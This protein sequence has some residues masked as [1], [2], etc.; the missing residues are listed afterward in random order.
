M[1]VCI[2][3]F[4]SYQLDFENEMTRF[5][6]SVGADLATKGISSLKN[7]KLNNTHILAARDGIVSAGKMV[8]M[9]LA[10]YLK[11]KPWGLLILLPKPMPYLQQQDSLWKHGIVIKG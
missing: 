3:R 2:Q 10:K 8:G 1:P 7:V 5:E 11:F 9:D 6:T 4:T